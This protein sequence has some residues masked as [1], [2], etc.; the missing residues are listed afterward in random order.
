MKRSLTILTCLLTSAMLFAQQRSESEALQV[1]RKFLQKQGVSPHLVNA[2]VPTNSSQR[3]S[4]PAK[5]S[6]GNAYYIFNDE[7]NHRFIIV[8]GDERLYNILGYSDCTLFD[9]ST[10]APALLELL[11]GYE[12]EYESI[13]ES[14]WKAK[15]KSGKVEFEDIQPILKTKWGQRKPF[16]DRC[17]INLKESTN[18]R[19]LSGCVATAMAQIMKHHSYPTKGQGYYSYATDFGTTLSEDFSSF[20]FDWNNMINEYTH[21]YTDE[22]AQAVADL[23]YACGVSVSMKYGEGSS[24]AFSSNIPYALINYFG[25]N[26]NTTYRKRRYYQDDEWMNYILSDLKANLPV[27]YSG[28][29]SVGKAGHQFIIDGCDTEGLFHFNFGWNGNSDGYYHLNLSDSYPYYPAEQAMSNQVC[30]GLYGNHEDIFY[31]GKLSVQKN[32]IHI[33]DNNNFYLSGAECWS[34]ETTYLEENTNSFNGEIGIALYDHDWQFVKSIYSEILQN[35]H[36]GGIG[37][38]HRFDVKFSSKDFEEGHS[39]R[40]APYAKSDK[41]TYATRIRTQHGAYD[42]YEAIV[43][44]GE[45]RFVLVGDEERLMPEGTYIATA[46]NEKGEKVEW[47]VYIKKD[48]I[49]EFYEVHSLDPAIGK[50]SGN[51]RNSAKAEYSTDFTTLSFRNNQNLGTN[52][53]DIVLNNYSNSGKVSMRT[54]AKNKVMYI[55]DVWGTIMTTKTDY[56][57]SEN[58]PSFKTE[59]L[60]R[61]TNTVF[62]YKDATQVVEQKVERPIIEINE[63]KQV[64]MIS[65]TEGA[66]VYYTTDGSTPNVSST[67]YE[68]VFPLNGNLTVKAVAI[69]D[70]KNSDVTTIDVKD[71]FVVSNPT[72]KAANGHV[73]MSCP[74]NADIRYTINGDEP[75]QESAIYKGEL[76]CIE[77]TLFKAI[78]YKDNYIPSEIVSFFF[79]APQPEIP[80]PDNKNLVALNVAAGSLPSRIPIENTQEAISLTVSGELNGTDIKHIREILQAGKLAY[81]NMEEATIVSGGEPYYISGNYSYITENYSIG[82]FMFA[83]MNG[84]ISIKLPKNTKRIGRNALSSCGK[85]SEITIPESCEDMN[86]RCLWFTPIQRLVIPSTIKQISSNALVGCKK[87]EEIDV[88]KNN[89]SYKSTD[90]VLFSKDD[91]VLVAYPANKQ[92]EDYLIPEGTQVI[93]EYAFAYANI[94]TIALPKTLKSIGSSAFYGC[95]KLQE[96]QIPD[97]VYQIGSHAFFDCASLCNVRLSDN[98]NRLG[99]F[100]FGFCTKLKEFC[101]GKNLNT[102][103]ETT[104]V[105][106][107]ALNEFKVNDENPYY[108]VIDGVLYSHDKIKVLRCPPAYYKEVFFIPSG[109]TTISSWCFSGCEN[110]S[111]YHFPESLAILEASSFYTS[112]IK[113]AHLPNGLKTMGSFSFMSCD[114]LESIIIP[115]GV[116]SIQSFLCANCKNLSYIQLPSSIRKIDNYAFSGCNSLSVINCRINNIDEVDITSVN[117]EYTSFSGICSDCTWR[118][119]KGTSERYK[120]QPWWV[121]TWKIIE[122]DTRTGI[123][124]K[125]SDSFDLS[126]QDGILCIA[127]NKD[128]MIR[129]YSIEGTLHHELKVKSG[130][131][132]QLKLQKGLYLINNKKY[133]FQ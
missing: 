101:I 13:V 96:I 110:I 84:L 34:S 82:D 80:Q 23:M 78:A 77:N 81:V 111:S 65:K 2:E 62:R 56:V 46:F 22:Q 3:K 94:F 21:S 79:E 104:F 51:N 75:T 16:N 32:T 36:Q 24:G 11:E 122:D 17:P 119:P 48:N 130:N 30:K 60:S 10:A 133:L 18:N 39:Y 120:A 118:I 102:I 61:Y 95:G 50:L 125:N 42:Y 108:C 66:D 126:W 69:K 98:V 86:E 74:D 53:A 6:A 55:D 29:P 106:C 93:N 116:E 72:I 4:G 57:S 58:K 31:A 115:E 131:E 19:S 105:G 35:K 9:A 73:I 71:L 87:L 14:G 52:N 43:K 121:P 1:A 85:L 128:G 99:D 117:G 109:T 123:D 68:D 33:G 92:D 45:I 54:D 132:Y 8:S 59:E 44:N 70:G 129:V 124:K 49:T 47:E 67:L 112:T 113:E 83:D 41:S 103:D 76:E 91:K 100:V 88:D 12:E 97:N 63:D 15:R 90:G 5:L 27:P 40:I 37:S 20:Q 25:Y 26:P 89:T 7:N 38:Y 114:S 127:P 28:R 64:V 107:K